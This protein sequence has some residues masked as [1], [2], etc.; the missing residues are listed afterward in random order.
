MH[1]LRNSRLAYGWHLLYKSS[2]SEVAWDKDC[3]RV[4]FEFSGEKNILHIS[5]MVE[6]FFSFQGS[7]ATFAVCTQLCFLTS[8]ICCA[9]ML[10]RGTEVICLA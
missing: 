3:H 1:Q 10:Q 4:C 8:A 2:S 6:I 7:P 9:C 5:W